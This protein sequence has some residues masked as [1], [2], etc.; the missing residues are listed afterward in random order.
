MFLSSWGKKI[1]EILR[2]FSY[3]IQEPL[4]LTA[5]EGARG[6]PNV[7]WKSQNHRIVLGFTP[8][9]KDKKEFTYRF[10]GLLTQ[11]STDTKS[12]APPPRTLVSKAHPPLPRPALGPEGLRGASGRLRQAREG[13]V[14]LL[15]PGI[16]PEVTQLGPHDSQV[17]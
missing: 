2:T 13:R 17:R 9:E 10:A 8:S 1:A 7:W 5:P 11:E 12:S 16:D 4:V 3:V 15:H 6:F 14:S